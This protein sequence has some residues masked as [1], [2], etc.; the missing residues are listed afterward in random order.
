MPLARPS[1]PPL[2]QPLPRIESVALLGRHQEI[3]ILHAGE[4]YRLRRTKQGKLILTK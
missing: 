1:C 3:E 4:T 2:P